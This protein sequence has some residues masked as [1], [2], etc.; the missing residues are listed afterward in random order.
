MWQIYAFMSV[1]AISIAVLLNKIAVRDRDASVVT[2]GL[3]GIAAFCLLPLIDFSFNIPTNL[4][5]YVFAAGAVYSAAALWAS[6]SYKNSDLSLIAPIK[7]FTPVFVLLLSAIFLGET[8]TMQ[9]IIGIFFVFIGA[10][11]LEN[12]KKP[13]KSLKMLA[14]N[15]GVKW[16]FLTMVAMSLGHILDKYILFNLDAGMFSVLLYW[17]IF[18]MLTV[19]IIFKKKIGLGISTIRNAPSIIFFAGF[20]EALSFYLQMLALRLVDVS[21]Y[22]PIRRTYSIIVVI[23]AYYILNEDNIKNKLFGVVLMVIGVII[24]GL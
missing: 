19:H 8:V 13:H 10:I 11:A 17:I 24:L 23:L 1:V 5:P 12:I 15:D 7:N 20:F 3:M 4:Y 9:K 14:L 21:I 6:K 16:A 22:V 18:V 2:W